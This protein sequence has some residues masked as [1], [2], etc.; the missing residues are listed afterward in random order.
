MTDR[1]Y[2]TYTPTTAPGSYHTAIHYERTDPAGNVVKHFVIEA[3]PE[4]LKEL[5]ALDKAIGV[6]EEAFRKDDGPSR[7]GRIDA[8]AWKQD[9]NGDPSA[10]YEIIA[11]GD[12]LSANFARM[13]LYAHG[14][15]R[16]GFGTI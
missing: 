11:E 4:K 12:D 1:I 8:R 2:V 16:A 15:N 7:F 3:Q 9:A 10:P 6:I 13:Q 5:S 14:F